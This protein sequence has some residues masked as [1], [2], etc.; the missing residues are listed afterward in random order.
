M[1]LDNYILW[2]TFNDVAGRL[3]NSYLVAY[4]KLV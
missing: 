4:V 3:N 1:K 2:H